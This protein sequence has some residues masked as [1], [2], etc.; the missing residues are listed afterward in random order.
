MCLDTI[1]HIK[2][3]SKIGFKIVAKC[4]ANDKLYPVYCDKGMPF[5]EKGWMSEKEYRPFWDNNFINISCG[6]QKYRSGFHIFVSLD[7]AISYLYDQIPFVDEKFVRLVLYKVKFD[8]VVATGLQ[9]PARPTVVAQKMKL[10]EEMEL[11]E[12]MKLK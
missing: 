2:L 5:I 8:L 3:K 9:Q 11:L 12:E 7:D 1:E 4:H 6:E 10:L